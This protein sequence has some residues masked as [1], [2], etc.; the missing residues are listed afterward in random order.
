MRRLAERAGYAVL[1]QHALAHLQDTVTALQHAVAAPGAVVDYQVLTDHVAKQRKFELTDPEFFAL[2]ERV[3][4]YT[5]TS[6]ERLYAMHNAVEYVARAGVSGAIVECGVWR[7]GSMMMAALTLAALGKIDREL[8]LFDTF[9]GHPRPNP[10]RDLKDHYEFWLQRRR[11]DESSSWAEATLEEVRANLSST[12]YPLDR[13]KLV[14]GIVQASIPAAAP[15]AIALLRLDTD[16]YDSTAHEMRHLYPRLVPGGVL[17][18][19]DYG[20]MQGQKQ[21]IDEFCQQNGVV[22]LL[23]RIDSSGRIAVK[24]VDLQDRPPS[25]IAGTELGAAG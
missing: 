24:S 13:M 14:K 6:I 1:P 21:A 22:L 12:G 8:I 15:E 20:E 11:T 9:A 3:R 2:Y 19:D 25:V 4:P 10:E 18:V 23:N 17:I 16:W 7:G 5:M